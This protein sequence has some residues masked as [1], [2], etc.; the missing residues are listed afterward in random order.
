MRPR[1][2]RQRQVC[3]MK[4]SGFSDAIIAEQLGITQATVRSHRTSVHMA[5]NSGMTNPW[6]EKRRLKKIEEKIETVPHKV[7]KKTP[8]DFLSKLQASG[9]QF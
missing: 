8:A 1:T 4:T 9:Q 5:R 3:E 7:K 2:P 6:N